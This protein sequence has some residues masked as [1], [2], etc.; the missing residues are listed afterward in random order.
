MKLP[1][2][3][4]LLILA[5]CDNTYG[6]ASEKPD[7]HRQALTGVWKERLPSNTLYFAGGN[8]TLTFTP[9]SVAILDHRFTDAAGCL[10]T[11]AGRTCSDFEWD[12]FYKGTYTVNDS[13]LTLSYVFDKTT[14]NALTRD[15][16]T[17]GGAAT[18]RYDLDPDG[19]GSLHFLV[20]GGSGIVAEKG[21]IDFK[22][23]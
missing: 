3:A 16:R 23:Q 17:E 10:Q 21:A 7:P 8:L 14:A 18:M 1:C 15:E 13:V 11:D 19:P 22:R 2:A 5:G 9:D 12:N 6:P 4:A 20:S